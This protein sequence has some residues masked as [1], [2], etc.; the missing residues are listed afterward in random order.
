MCSIE[1]QRDMIF[2]TVLEVV[3]ANGNWRGS[4][5]SQMLSSAHLCEW[6]QMDAN[7]HHPHAVGQR[8]V[9]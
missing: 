6:N 5:R 3:I 7:T 1:N 8:V 9:G 4:Y 2:E